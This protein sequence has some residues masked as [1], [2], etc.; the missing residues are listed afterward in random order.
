V[1]AAAIYRFVENPIRHAIR[2][3]RHLSAGVFGLACLGLAAFAALPA[4]LAWLQGGWVWRLPTE[5]Q[6]AARDTDL[7]RF[8][9]LQYVEAEFAQQAFDPTQTNVLVVGD[10]HAVDFYNA[11]HL[12]T[13]RFPGFE[14]RYLSL[15]DKCFY[16][17]DP[18]ARNDERKR[19][20][21]DECTRVAEAFRSS[22]LVDTADYVVVSSRWKPQ[23][24][25]YLDAFHR[26]LIRRGPELVLLG[27]SAEFDNVPDLVVR[28]GRLRGIERY[29]AS[30]R[31]TG[32]DDLNRRIEE[33]AGQLSVRYRDKLAFL[34]SS[35]R[36]TCD[37]FD[38]E[39]N[40]L[41]YDD[42]HWT[43]AGARHFGARMAASGFLGDL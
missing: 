20:T 41:Y 16:R 6:D 19:A 7:K 43:V 32:P 21:H 14:F 17:F 24:L 22:A 36:A 5:I 30:H 13:E 9:S 15:D 23:S 3:E 10:S 40:L 18:A 8:R 25:Q 28:F 4:A 42:S 2:R 29:V 31:R 38:R 11:L 35:D 27:R 1:G 26:H 39:G 33:K 34:C 12:N 37:V